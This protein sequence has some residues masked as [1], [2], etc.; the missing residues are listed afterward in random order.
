MILDSN[1]IIYSALPDHAKLRDFIRDNS[2]YV[3]DIS[4]VEVMGYNKLSGDD[5]RYF[6]SFFEATTL[7]PVSDVVIL[8]AVSLRQQRMM[9]LGD[10]IVAASAITNNFSLVTSNT[11][12]FKWINRLAL[13]NPLE[14]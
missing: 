10:S 12:D 1:I 9:S 13:I 6:D 2:P 14:E 7:I 4:K 3:S 8:E 11:K 5:L